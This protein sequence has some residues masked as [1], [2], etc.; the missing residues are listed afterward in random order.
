VVREIEID[1]THVQLTRECCWHTGTRLKH[2]S[3]RA[4]SFPSDLIK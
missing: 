1:G 4:M 3:A 2:I